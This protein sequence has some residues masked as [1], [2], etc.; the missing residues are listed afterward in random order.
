MVAWVVIDR[1]QS[2]RS[3]LKGIAKTPFTNVFRSFTSFTSSISFIS[4]CF[5]TL[6]SFFASP[7]SPTLFFSGSSALF[8][9]NKGFVSFPATL[10][11]DP[12]SFRI[13]ISPNRGPK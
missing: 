10:F 6:L 13:R 2:T 7:E 4:C 5:R 3:D 11:P 12:K 9:K 1:R 8:H